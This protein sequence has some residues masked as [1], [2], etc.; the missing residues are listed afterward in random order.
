LVEKGD[1]EAAFALALKKVAGKDKKEKKYVAGLETAFYHLQ[2]RDLQEIEYL[3]SKNDARSLDKVVIIYRNMATRQAKVESLM[4]LISFEG[5]EAKFQ[6]INIHAKLVDAEE[7]AAKAYY[8]EG[9]MYLHDSQRLQNKSLAKTAY[10]SFLSAKLYNN[11]LTDIN[12]YIDE[13][14]HNAITYVGL[15][16]LNRSGFNPIVDGLMHH[17][18]ELSFGNLNSE[19]IRYMDASFSDV[20]L[21]RIVEM[22]IE[23]FDLGINREIVNN[24]PITSTINIGDVAIKHDDTTAYKNEKSKM[25]TSKKVEQV[26]AHVSEVHKEKKSELIITLRLFNT[27]LKSYFYTERINVYSHF[28]NVSATFKG[29]KRALDEKT[30]QLTNIEPMAF[31]TDRETMHLLIAQLHQMVG[32]ILMN[33]NCYKKLLY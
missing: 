30:L 5:Y 28:N 23:H 22:N 15:N 10:H 12:R 1:Y 27:K 8:E 13:S 21:D 2:K 19:W 24:Y 14:Y 3:Q 9:K 33:R 7:I 16:I 20:A 17:L 26:T 6:F 4:P 18:D 29:D 32:K 25:E 31:P 11:N